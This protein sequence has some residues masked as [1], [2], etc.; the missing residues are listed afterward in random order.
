MRFVSLL[1]KTF[2]QCARSRRSSNYV[3][4]ATSGAFSI[5][6]INLNTHTLFVALFIHEYLVTIDQEMHLVWTSKWRLS[7][8]IFLA[9]R[10]ASLVI[11]IVYAIP[12]IDYQVSFFS[13][14]HLARIADAFYT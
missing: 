9:N 3:S 4:F 5:F 12:I 11:A 13:L 7:A 14:T 6:I 8:F 10:Y 1:H 2:N